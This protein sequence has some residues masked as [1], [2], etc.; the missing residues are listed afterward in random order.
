MGDL[1]TIEGID[2]SGK[3]T[4]TNQ[5]FDKI[6]RKNEVKILKTAEPTNTWLGRV[7]KNGLNKNLHP[8]SEA[9]LF[10]SDHIEHVTNVIKPALESNK[11]VISDRYI[12]SFYAYQGATL[13]SIIENP[14]EYLKNLRCNFTIKPDLTLL[15]IVKPDTAISRLG[16]NKIK[17]EEVEFLER[18]NKN[19]LKLAKEE[20]RFVKIDAEAPM[21]EVIGEAY[22]KIYDFLNF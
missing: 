10:T 21:E 5:V 14:I 9:F 4:I 8:L 3:S 16:K 7:V 17:F 18:V 2:G 13:E 12:D 1:I 19:Y 11:N 22:E 6:S 15:M 20:E